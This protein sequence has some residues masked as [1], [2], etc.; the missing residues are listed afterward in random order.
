MKIDS[1]IIDGKNQ[2]LYAQKRDIIIQ[3]NGMKKSVHFIYPFHPLKQS[4]LDQISKFDKSLTRSSIIVSM[5]M[6]RANSEFKFPL[7]G[8]SHLRFRPTKRVKA[9]SY[10]VIDYTWCY[11]N[12]INWNPFRYE[13]TSSEVDKCQKIESSQLM[14]KV[15]LFI[16]PNYNAFSTPLTIGN[17]SMNRFAVDEDA[18]SEILKILELEKPL[19]DPCN[20]YI[21]REE[22]RKQKEMDLIIRMYCCVGFSV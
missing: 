5:D 19:F 1:N 4:E 15:V 20:I 13:I 8:D 10:F 2:N 7:F 12:W 11:Q 21:T 3:T 18:G 17:L 22:Q 16:E 14:Q 6:A 9:D